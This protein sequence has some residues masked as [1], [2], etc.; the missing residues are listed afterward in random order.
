MNGVTSQVKSGVCVCVG[1]WRGRKCVSRVLREL[2]FACAICSVSAFVLVFPA[3]PHFCYCS[4]R[5][6]LGCGGLVRSRCPQSTE[7]SGSTL[8]RRRLWRF[9]VGLVVVEGRCREDWFR[10]D[11]HW[12]GSYRSPP[13]ALRRFSKS[14]CLRTRSQRKQ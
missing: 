14:N 11:D 5:R 4:A 6:V 2:K 10:D 13:G 12:E 8:H 1:S 3:R 7:A 9:A